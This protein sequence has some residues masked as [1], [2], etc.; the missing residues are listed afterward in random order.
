MR[1][2]RA[3]HL[4]MCFGVRDAI[5]LALE[6]AGAGPL[7]ILGDLVH[8]PTVLSSLEAKGIAVEQ[9]LSRVKTPTLMVTA[10]GTSERTLARTRALGLTVVEATCPLVRV[11]HRAVAVLARDG[12]HVVIVGQRDHV[13]VRGLTGDLD[14]DRFDVVLE[15]DDVLALDE[16]PRFGVAA[17]TTQPLEKVRRLVELIRQRFPRSS[18]RF[19][20]TVCKPT[21]ERQSSAIEMA[22]QADVVIVVGG[23]SSNN[24]RELVKTCSRYCSRVHHVQT[25]ADVRPEWFDDAHV[26]GLTAGTSTP[27]D[28]IDRVEARMRGVA[29]LAEVR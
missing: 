5:A 11:A 21:K 23:R 24:T 2:L 8:N 12:Y 10:H 14:P 9:D 13:E 4:G 17:Q 7:T 20:D 22:R 29:A 28:V 6:H 25:D 18:V 1:I 27:D 15:D 16:H 3:A 26:V 19:L